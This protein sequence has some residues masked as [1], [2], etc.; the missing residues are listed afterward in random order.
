MGA[1]PARAQPTAL[2]SPPTERIEDD[3][4]EGVERWRAGDLTL[5][6]THPLAVDETATGT[7]SLE[8]A[9]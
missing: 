7:L 9:P 5:L 8:P 4:T 2:A 6:A 1:S 3:G